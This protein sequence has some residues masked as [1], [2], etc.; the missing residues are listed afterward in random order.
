MTELRSSEKLN[1]NEMDVDSED[2]MMTSSFSKLDLGRRSF[3]IMINYISSSSSSG[4][5]HN[6]LSSF[7]SP[8]KA[9]ALHSAHSP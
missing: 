1:R 3:A 4:G 8:R 9:P 5:Y 7:L 2:A 6:N